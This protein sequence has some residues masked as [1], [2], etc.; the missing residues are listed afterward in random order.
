MLMNLLKNTNGNI[1]TIGNTI[2]YQQNVSVNKLGQFIVS[3]IDN[4]LKRFTIA[5]GTFGYDARY[6]L[7]VYHHE[8]DEVYVK[9]GYTPQI[10]H[11]GDNPIWD[12]IIF[13]DGN[14]ELLY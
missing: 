1:E 14:Y 13:Q 11:V 8:Q 7:Y 9:Q 2:L 10:I 12:K 3:D 5:D 4:T 6:N